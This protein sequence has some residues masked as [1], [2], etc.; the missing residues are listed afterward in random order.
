VKPCQFPGCERSV[1]SFEV[2]CQFHTGVLL[3]RI[4]KRFEPNPPPR[5]RGIRLACAIMMELEVIR[6]QQ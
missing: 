2:C 5:L 1:A 4:A 3:S 6:M